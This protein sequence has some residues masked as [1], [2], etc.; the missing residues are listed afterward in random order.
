MLHPE[1]R[2]ARRGAASQA[3]RVANAAQILLCLVTMVAH[4]ALFDYRPRQETAA[5]Y[6]ALTVVLIAPYVLAQWQRTIPETLTGPA[7]TTAWSA[8]LLVGLLVWIIPRP[9]DGAGAGVTHAAQSVA[10][11]E[12]AALAL[13]ALNVIVLSWTVAAG[14]RATRPPRG[15]TF[16]VDGALLIT[17]GVMMLALMQFQ[18][19]GWIDRVRRG[20][21]DTDVA[22]RQLRT[23]YACLLRYRDSDPLQSFP[24]DL[25]SLLLDERCTKPGKTDGANFTLEYRPTDRDIYGRYTGFELSVLEHTSVRRL[26]VLWIDRDGTVRSGTLPGPAPPL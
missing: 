17:I 11:G 22:E 2:V 12:R 13:F 7:I 3:W 18:R 15:R 4:R 21:F 1:P 14:W 23:T 26:R 24:R 5:P 6:L 16:E 8:L 25:G 20:G 9:G 10:S 19:S